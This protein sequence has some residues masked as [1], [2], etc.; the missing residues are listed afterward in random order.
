MTKFKNLLILSLIVSQIK[1]TY[2]FDKGNY[3]DDSCNYKNNYKFSTK[4][5]FSFINCFSLCF[6]TKL[7]HDAASKVA[8]SI[9]NKMQHI[10]EG[11]RRH[12]KVKRHIKVIQLNKGSSNFD[13]YKNLLKR[14]LSN[15]MAEKLYWGRVT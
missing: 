5:N 8:A 12:I 10:L 2:E 13:T 9:H 7:H 11:N 14:E 4:L 3:H 15:H 1:F 6:I